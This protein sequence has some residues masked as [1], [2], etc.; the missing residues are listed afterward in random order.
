MITDDI[1]LKSPA[2]SLPP[3]GIEFIW[4]ITDYYVQKDL[5]KFLTYVSL[6]YKKGF[7]N[8][9]NQLRKVFNEHQ[10]LRLFVHLRS[11][12]LEIE[13]QMHFYGICWSRR[14]RRNNSFFIEKNTGRATI[15]LKKIRS[16]YSD[17]F[18][19]YDIEGDNPFI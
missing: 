4:Q 1:Y 16:N 17:Y 2:I 18:L 9:E 11:K 19:L 5:T 12:N 8:F 13:P 10:H 7:F 14:S 15:A 6:E 3:L